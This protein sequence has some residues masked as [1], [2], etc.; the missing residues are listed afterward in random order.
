MSMRIF[1]KW[2]SII[3]RFSGIYYSEHM[4]SLGLSS[5]QYIFFLCICDHPGLTQDELAAEL[6][7]NK[8]TVARVVAS[9]EKNGF[10][11]RRINP[12]DKRAVNLYPTQRA[13]E[14]YPRVREILDEWNLRITDGFTSEESDVFEALLIRASENARRHAKLAKEKNKL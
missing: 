14:I 13:E 8:S 12:Q 2:I 5:G 7:F 4:E 11:E 10:V 9:L 1:G 6:A 3:S